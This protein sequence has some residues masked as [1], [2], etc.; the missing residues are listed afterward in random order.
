MAAKHW[1]SFASQNYFDPNGV[2]VGTL[3][4]AP[5]IFLALVILFNGLYASSKLLI[6]VKRKEITHRNSQLKSDKFKPE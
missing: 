5:L 6:E 2:F 1:K 3:F 4:G